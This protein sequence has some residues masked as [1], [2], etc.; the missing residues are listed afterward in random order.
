[1]SR[2]ERRREQREAE[3]KKKTFVL[4][5]EELERY[6]NQAY[7]MARSEYL[8]KA[9]ELDA[10]YKKKFT[11]HL[12]AVCEEE[13]NKYLAKHAELSEEIFKM[14]LVIPT[15][16]LIEDYW[17]KTAE[18][19][20]PGYIDACLELYNSWTVGAVSMSDMQALTEKYGKFQLVEIDTATGKAL[21][22]RKARGID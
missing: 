22:E 4:T 16:V 21:E 12:N 13:R 19:K 17:P 3:A 20:I 6:R 11:E 15:N 5:A 10:E 9:K 2:A 1:M 8:Q 7:E 18:R 14:M